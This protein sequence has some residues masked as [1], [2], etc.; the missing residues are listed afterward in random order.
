MSWDLLRPYIVPSLP[1]QDQ[2]DT[3]IV[4]NVLLALM[5]EKAQLWVYY[6]DG[7]E[8]LHKPLALIITTIAEDIVARRYSLLVYTAMALEETMLDKDYEDIVEV[9]YSYANGR[10]M[11]DVVAYAQDAA[12]R[13]W[14]SKGA[15][16]ISN[17]MRL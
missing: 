11:S 16:K 6:R 17:F 12:A 10:G 8:D 15:K 3:E 2:I 7:E 13:F 9:L 4:S 14:A 1:R 5:L